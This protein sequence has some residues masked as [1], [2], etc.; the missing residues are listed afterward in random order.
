MN[1]WYPVRFA[2]LIAACGLLFSACASTPPKH[3]NE[4]RATYAQ[5]A[6]NSHAQRYAPTELKRAKQTLLRAEQAY[7]QSADSPATQT[8][9]YLALRR[10]QQAM[11]S[12]ELNYLATTRKAQENKLFARTEAARQHFQQQLDEQRQS[13]ATAR[14]LNAQQLQQQ[15]QQ[16]QEAL[17]QLDEQQMSRAD[18]QALQA[19]YQDAMA[20]LDAEIA[21][22]EQAEERLQEVTQRLEQI[23]EVRQDDSGETIITLD[24]ATLFEKGKYALLPVARQNLEQVAEALKMQPET[25]L[26]VAGFTSSTGSQ[27]FNQ[28]LSQDRAESVRDYL[29]SRGIPDE[30]IETIGYGQDRPV[31]SNDTSEGRAMNRRVEIILNPSEATGGGPTDSPQLDTP[32]D[33][34]PLDDSPGTDSPGSQNPP[35]DR[36]LPPVDQVIPQ[37]G[38]PGDIS[39]PPEQFPGDDAIQPESS[40]TESG[41]PEAGEDDGEIEGQEDWPAMLDNSSDERP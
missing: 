5:A 28:S 15:R 34:S 33:D 31:A 7:A 38:P 32:S 40:E 14:Q 4:A 17:E 2:G 8:L 19:Q 1:T 23:A 10:A 9:A 21:R 41:E 29:V 36:P 26:T 18:T 35:L 6:Q 30:R 27:E 22:R 37:E 16:L 39:A 25:T 20:R 24:S 13:A 11:A 12:A 3:L